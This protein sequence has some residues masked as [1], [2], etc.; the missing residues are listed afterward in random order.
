MVNSRRNSGFEHFLPF[1]LAENQR[2]TLSVNKMSQ[3]DDEFS[4][5]RAVSAKMFRLSAEFLAPPPPPPPHLKTI[6]NPS[7][8]INTT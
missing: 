7:C 2:K 3:K 4:T 1:F 8:E 6:G 5:P